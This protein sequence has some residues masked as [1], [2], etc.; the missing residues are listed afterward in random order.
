[1]IY[2]KKRNK[3]ELEESDTDNSPETWVPILLSVIDMSEGHR[4]SEL[5]VHDKVLLGS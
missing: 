5:V 2:E 3:T 4:C 1:L